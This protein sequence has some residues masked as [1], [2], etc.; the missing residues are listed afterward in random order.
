MRLFTQY[1]PTRGHFGHLRFAHAPRADSARPACGDGRIRLDDSGFDG[2]GSNP[3]IC[4]Q[5]G[6]GLL[7]RPPE[8]GL[9]LDLGS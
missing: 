2:M 4:S 8:T 3:R 6:Q 5:E 9:E 1:L 7:I